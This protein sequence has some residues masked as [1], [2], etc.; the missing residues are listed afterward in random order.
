MGGNYL[1]RGGGLGQFAD[2]RGLGKK[3]GG[4]AGG[5]T[6]ITLCKLE[7]SNVTKRQ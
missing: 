6:P 7:E 1:K 4:G 3:E 5:D 2:L